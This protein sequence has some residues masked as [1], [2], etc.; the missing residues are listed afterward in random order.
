[1]IIEENKWQPFRLRQ[2]YLDVSNSSATETTT[3]ERSRCYTDN[4]THP[5]LPLHIIDMPCEQTARYVIVETT[6][7]APEDIKAGEHGAILE[8]CEIE[9]YG[10]HALYN[11]IFYAICISFIWKSAYNKSLK[12]ITKLTQTV[13]HFQMHDHVRILRS[14]FGGY[15]LVPNSIIIP[16]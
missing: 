7:H 4:T 12:N 9:V 2:F 1:M 16:F 15:F 14:I 5:V 3:L 8:V 10:M 11:T 13:V 6:Y